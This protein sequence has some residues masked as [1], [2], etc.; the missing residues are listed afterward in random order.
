[1]GISRDWETFGTVTRVL[2]DPKTSKKIATVRCVSKDTAKSVVEE[3][4]EIDDLEAVPAR[5]VPRPGIPI[6]G[7]MANNDVKVRLRAERKDAVASK[8]LGRPTF[9]DEG[10]VVDIAP[11]DK[12]N[13]KVL[14]LCNGKNPEELTK[15]WYEPEDLEIAE[16][17]D[18]EGE[19]VFGGRVT[20][21]STVRVRQ[22][23]RGKK[24]LGTIEVGDIGMIKGIDP[25]AADNLRINVTCGRSMNAK[26]SEWYD[27]RDLEIF[28]QLEDAGS[29]L[30]KARGELQQTEREL[31]VLKTRPEAPDLAKEQELEKKITDLKEKVQKLSGETVDKNKLLEV[32]RDTKEKL[33]DAD[34]LKREIESMRNKASKETT[35]SPDTIRVNNYKKTVDGIYESWVRD[36][37][38]TDVISFD[39]NQNISIGP[40]NQFRALFDELRKEMSNRPEGPPTED[41]ISSKTYDVID[42]LYWKKTEL[43][44]ELRKFINKNTEMPT[45]QRY[46]E[47]KNQLTKLSYSKFLYDKLKANPLKSWYDDIDK[48]FQ[49]L[50]ELAYDIQ[51][52]AYSGNT[53]TEKLLGRIKKLIEEKESEST[54]VDE[55]LVA[56]TAKYDEILLSQREARLKSEIAKQKYDEAYRKDTGS[57]KQQQNQQKKKKGGSIEKLTKNDIVKIVDYIIPYLTK[58]LVQLDINTDDVKFKIKE[59]I[60]NEETPYKDTDTYTSAA[61]HYAVYYEYPPPIDEN[62]RGFIKKEIQKSFPKKSASASPEQQVPAT[63]TKQTVKNASQSEQISAPAANEVDSAPAPAPAAQDY[64]AE[65]NPLYVKDPDNSLY[66]VPADNTSQP[67][68][69]GST[70]LSDSETNSI[71]NKV[72]ER[73]MKPRPAPYA[74]LLSSRKNQLIS[75]GLTMIDEGKR[76]NEIL[77]NLSDDAAGTIYPKPTTSAVAD[78]FKTQREQSA[79]DTYDQIRVELDNLVEKT[80][81][82]KDLLGELNKAVKEYLKVQK[83]VLSARKERDILSGEATCLRLTLQ[84]AT[85]LEV[86]TQEIVRKKCTLVG[87]ADKVIDEANSLIDKRKLAFLAAQAAFD[88]TLGQG[89]NAGEFIPPIGTDFDGRIKEL[90][91]TYLSLKTSRNVLIVLANLVKLSGEYKNDKLLP[92]AIKVVTEGKSIL[93][94]EEY[95]FKT[96]KLASELKEYHENRL[97]TKGGASLT[98]AADLLARTYNPSRIEQA[99]A[100]ARARARAQA[101]A[102]APETPTLPPTRLQR[103]K[104]G[105]TNA[106]QGISEGAITVWNKTPMSAEARANAAKAKEKETEERNKLIEKVYNLAKALTEDQVLRLRTRTVGRAGSLDLARQLTIEAETLKTVLMESKL[107]LQLKLSN[108]NQ[109]DL[110]VSNSVDYYSSEL[111][112]LKTCVDTSKAAATDVYNK[113]MEEIKKTSDETE[114]K[115][116]EVSKP[117]Q[118]QQGKKDYK[119]MTDEELQKEIVDLQQRSDKFSNLIKTKEVENPKAVPEWQRQKQNLDEKRKEAVAERDRRKTGGRR[120]RFTMRQPKRFHGY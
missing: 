59:D 55:K 46:A 89:P 116:F 20:V 103:I 66:Q 11:T 120:R 14:V 96:R 109:D 9:G 10:T 30:D 91:S 31:A 71:I 83:E 1:M 85:D 23:A 82:S 45:D 18:T 16:P 101:Q 58:P 12:D 63:K 52:H 8:P 79:S 106:A 54:T 37:T 2:A 95:T 86:K 90:E 50:R 53:P 98:P 93:E 19:A 6:F 43:D 29:E 42:T 22:S 34:G 107:D 35:C 56:A 67:S 13:L 44:S 40:S 26:Q 36:K 78:I 62:Y 105:V 72:I 68:T 75:L 113:A 28:F 4:Y 38:D 76:T 51:A 99:R 48:K 41:L 24:C 64:R 61:I 80:V 39:P 69:G 47:M 77:K 97:Q 92:E 74:K 49:K 119:S 7:G 102:P 21:G 81:D 15:E 118:G 100:R 3:D 25:N 110:K 84:A 112:K 27:P 94:D 108:V 60:S 33:D 115:F 65:K 5:S 104:E 111:K 87:D 17:D 88:P 70:T 114:N 73:V 117:Q 57:Q 32:Y